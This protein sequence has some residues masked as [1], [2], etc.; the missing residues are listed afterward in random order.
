MKLWIKILNLTNNNATFE[1]IQDGC[2]EAFDKQFMD[3]I[4]KLHHFLIK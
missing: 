2:F 3:E 4:H 1:Q